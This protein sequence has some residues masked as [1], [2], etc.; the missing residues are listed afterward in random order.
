MIGMMTGT[1]NSTVK[2]FESMVIVNTISHLK[3]MANVET[4]KPEFQIKWKP[5]ALMASSELV[6]Q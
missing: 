5:S 1:T 3:E 2:T 6:L 4:S